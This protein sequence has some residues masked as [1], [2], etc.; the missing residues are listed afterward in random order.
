MEN[1]IINNKQITL[2]KN[3]EFTFKIPVLINATDCEFKLDAVDIDLHKETSVA[4]KLRSTK[5]GSEKEKNQF[6]VNI[7]NNSAIASAKDYDLEGEFLLLG[8]ISN[9]DISFSLS[10]LRNAVRFNG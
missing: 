7:I 5:S 6:V 9:K 8:C 4:F 1:F 2:E 10:I 3:K